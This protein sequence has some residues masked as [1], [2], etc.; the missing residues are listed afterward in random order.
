MF[1]KTLCA[2]AV[3]ALSA[4]VQAAPLSTVLNSTGAA[5]IQLSI[6]DMGTTTYST[7][8]N[9]NTVATCDTA[10]GTSVGIGSEDTWGIAKVTEL[11][12]GTSTWTSGDSGQYI[13]GMF[14]GLQDQSVS[15]NGTAFTSV[16][17]GGFLD[18]Y[19][20]NADNNVNPNIQTPG[21]RTAFDAFTGFTGTS[22]QLF[23][24]LVFDAFTSTFKLVN[25]SGTTS[26]TVEG[27]LS[28]TN[29]A[30][31]A[32]SVFDTNTVTN[33]NNTIS[34]LT[35]TGSPLCTTSATS[36]G[37]W[38]TKGSI[39]A[40]GYAVPEPESL[41]LAGFGLVGLAAARRRKLV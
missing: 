21:A 5:T 12:I 32:N 4:G 14:Y 28:V 11:S 15:F 9:C 22:G 17:T 8:V 33:F 38:T 39:T 18:L 10:A 29:A 1:K 40:D 27:G 41:A 7:S 19:L 20:F 30:L 34:D 36:C 35:A 24:R 13:R 37:A 3:A 16:S 6:L 31:F 26:S 23:M 25:N 2:A